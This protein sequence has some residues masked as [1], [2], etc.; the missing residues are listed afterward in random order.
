MF[1]F[2]NGVGYKGLFLALPGNQRRTKKK[3]IISG[4]PTIGGISCPNSIK[5]CRE[6]KRRLSRVEK[7]MEDNAL[8]VSKNAQNNSIVSRLWSK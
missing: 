3:V 1:Y 7:A 6:N 2:S 4:G 8:Q 5:E